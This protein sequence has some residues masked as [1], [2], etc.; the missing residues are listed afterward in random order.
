MSK[1]N[2]WAILISL[3]IPLAVG[4]I[5]G[6]LISGSMSF[7]E[8]INK[9]PLAPPGIIF[10]FV[11][12]ILYILMGISSYLVYKEKTPESRIGL[13]IYAAQ[14]IVN[15]IWPLVFFN[16]RAFLAAFIIIL[17]LDVLVALMIVKFFKVSKVAAYLQI[18][19]FIWLLFATYLN[20]FVWLL[21]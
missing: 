5:S 21:N 10:P 9:P 13:Y 12:G 14:L 3:F 20:L 15:F 18:P 4:G 2:I 8:T 16:A 17:L 6:L 1:R 7:Y 11:W 19:Y